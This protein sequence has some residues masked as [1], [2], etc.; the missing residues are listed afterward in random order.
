MTLP[1]ILK[2][3]YLDMKKIS[4]LE[5]ME[6]IDGKNN[7]KDY[8]PF[9]SNVVTD[10]RMVKKGSLY[11]ALEGENFDGHDFI[12]EAIKKGAFLVISQKNKSGKEIINV[13]DT[14]KALGK[15]SQAYLK[16][17]N[18]KKVGITGSSGK[19]TTKDMVYHALSSKFKSHRTIGNFNNHIGLPLTVLSLEEDDEVGV[20]EMG[21]SELLEIDY[22]ANLVRPNFGIITNIGTSHIENLK[23]RENIFKAKMEIC[24][25]MTEKDILIVNGDDEFLSKLNKKDF[26]FRIIKFGFGKSND[27][28]AYDYSSDSKNSIFK[29]KAEK[30]EF[31]VEIPAIGRHNVLNCLA[32]IAIS[33]ELNLSNQEIQKGLKSFKPSKLRIDIRE[34]NGAKLINDS[35]N[36]N[37]ESM[38]A[39]IESLND[40]GLGRKV[41]ILGDMLE[42]GDLSRTKH[43]EI[44]EIAIKNCDICIFIGTEMKFA[45]DFASKYKKSDK[46][47]YHFID[48]NIAMNQ[49][50]GIINYGDIV[51]IKGS[52]GM[53]LDEIAEFLLENK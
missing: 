13:E 11:V 44:G 19:T 40:Y 23:T 27:I 29:V 12:E 24:N 32:A 38:K 41:A 6:F 5:I 46:S 15:L 22:L 4:K 39:V 3:G 2:E 48:R 17:F 18:I 45:S 34:V 28:I 37:P 53:K 33:I 30:R 26:E 43:E 36:A 8:N 14:Y 31:I 10:S 35:Y 25:Y 47:I 51:L 49:I 50:K 20:F 9:I 1:L 21:M 42:L 7:Y 52:R 16:C